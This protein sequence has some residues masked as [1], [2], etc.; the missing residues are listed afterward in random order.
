MNKTPM[1]AKLSLAAC[2]ER[3]IVP[4][5]KHADRMKQIRKYDGL[6]AH[7]DL[8]AERKGVQGHAGMPLAAHRAYALTTKLQAWASAGF[9]QMK[10]TASDLT[11]PRTKLVKDGTITG[12][13]AVR[14][15]LRRLVE[16]AGI[17]LP[18]GKIVGVG[19]DGQDK[20]SDA[21]VPLDYVLVGLSDP[22]PRR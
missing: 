15:V 4:A 3:K 6:V 22:R 10:L 18:A 9:P 19:A 17:A 20:G 7:R 8:I 14:S 16:Q 2:Q 1:T 12:T 5:R 13:A 11:Y 21:N